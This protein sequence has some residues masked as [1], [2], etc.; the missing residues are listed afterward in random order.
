MEIR[1]CYKP[2]LILPR[3]LAV[4]YLTAHQEFMQPLKLNYN[5]TYKTIWS[6][7]STLSSQPRF[8]QNTPK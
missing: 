1:K 3:E 8:T 6:E 7:R 5:P 2:G 4:K